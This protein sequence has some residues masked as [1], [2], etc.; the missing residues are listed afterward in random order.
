MEEKGGT[1]M[2]ALKKS[3]TRTN[4]TGPP[5]AGRH[6]TSIRASAVL[7]PELRLEAA[8]YGIAA[9]M[10]VEAIIGSGLQSLPLYGEQGF[11]RESHNAFRFRRV[12]VDPNHGVPFISSSDIIRLDDPADSFLSRKH[13]K[14]LDRLL[15]EKA[16]VLISCSG[17]VGNVSLAGTTLAGKALSQHA[18]RLRASSPEEAGFIAAFL[19]GRYGRPQLVGAKYGSVISHIEP[20]H[21]KSVIIPEP[22]PVLQI[23]IGRKMVEA[24][25]LRDEANRLIAE[26]KSEL[27]SA[28]NLP[29]LVELQSK[30]KS[31]PVSTSRV[32]GIMDRLDASYHNPLVSL[33]EERLDGLA[34]GCLP[35]GSAKLTSEIRPITKFRKRV[36]VKTGGIPLI[37]SKQLFQFDPIDVD[38]LAKGAHQKDL[39]EIALKKN[40]VAVSRSGTVGRVQ[41][42]PKYMEGWAGSEHAIR[43]IAANGINPGFLFAWLASDYGHALITRYQ[44]GS[45]ILEIDKDM[46]GRVPVPVLTAAVQTR[47][48]DLVLRAN[49]L[50]DD[51]WNRELDAISSLEDIVQRGNI[52][53]APAKDISTR[54]RKLVATWKNDRPATSSSVKSLTLHPAYQE[55]IEM[56]DDALPL[57][58]EELQER[59]D[60]WFVALRTI[61][62]ENPIRREHQGKMTLMA[63]DWIEW[64]VTKGHLSADEQARGTVS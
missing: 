34:K 28:L 14:N 19:R 15:I 54:F 29:S 40:M 27:L 13:T 51:A 45:V 7:S 33:I 3:L 39:A 20:E 58:L 12:Y 57:I 21:L 49:D 48:G 53:R 6:S 55:I 56:G 38:F 36:Y 26:A 18:I 62:G 41:I 60:H 25:D 10:A 46:L 30:V 4:R 24:T 47:I 35:L 44:Y 59:P 32:V 43:V 16:D 11:S 61:T 64:A 37:S 17:T 63:K 8:A 52:R 9:R 50:R 2:V 22:L 23:E 42:I 1:R 5:I 31:P